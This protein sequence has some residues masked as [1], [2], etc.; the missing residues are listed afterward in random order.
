M[1]KLNI[2]VRIAKNISKEF[3]FHVP[4][5]KDLF[6]GPME[7]KTLHRHTS[8]VEGAC[9]AVVKVVMVILVKI[10]FREMN[11]VSQRAWHRV[12]LNF[13]AI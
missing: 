1:A 7:G 2:F 9:L 13:V 8:L 11:I 3:C 10:D 4:K 5:R 6:D 12:T